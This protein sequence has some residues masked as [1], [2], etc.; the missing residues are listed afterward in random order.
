MIGED[1]CWKLIRRIYDAAFQP[2]LWNSVLEAISDEVGGAGVNISAI[3]AAKNARFFLG[4]ARLDPERSER[5]LNNPIYVE[6]TNAAWASRMAASP[7]GT[8]VHREAFWSDRE[9]CLSP[10]YN[11]IIRPQGL[12]HWAFA[13]LIQ[14][15]D[16]IIPFA[17][18]RAPGAP[19][20]ERETAGLLAQL[21]PHLARAVQMS[22][23]LDSLQSGARTMEALIDLLP[24][25][26]I[27]VNAE[28]KVVRCNRV[29]ETVLST[30]DGLTIIRGMLSATSMNETAAL[31]RLIAGTAQTGRGQ[32]PQ[33]GG[34]MSVSRRSPKRD[35]A[36]MV[37][38]LPS[39]GG[40][41]HE[42]A[43]RAI[44]FV[45]DPERKPRPPA[46]LL[47]RLYGLT[48]R[49]ASLA[50]CL[51]QGD[52]LSAAA[53]ALGI[54]RNT[55]RSHLRLIFEKTGAR[56]QTELTRLLAANMAAIGRF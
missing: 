19:L 28:A 34:A 6:P 9:F 48:A 41:L 29:A 45:S 44:V 47:A 13:P 2:E 55:A 46:E 23:R 18:L 37:A 42:T 51:A 40:R 50:L 22:L 43:A 49:Q 39:H 11:D 38:P 15:A 21:L 4:I 16:M 30:S 8:L 36:V 17:V 25:G 33:H 7:V 20:F 27:L 32:G 1:E 31:R 14:R 24:I 26:V 3:D 10:L 56:R 5:F 53:V 35:L 54:S 52:T 12:W